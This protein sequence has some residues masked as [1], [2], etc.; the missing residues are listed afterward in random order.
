MINNS[1]N[2]HIIVIAYDPIT[3]WKGQ[4]VHKLLDI[5]QCTF[6]TISSGHCWCLADTHKVFA[7]P[8]LTHAHTDAH[9]HREVDRGYKGVHCPGPRDRRGLELGPH[10]KAYI[11]WGGLLR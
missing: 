4:T 1:C 9:A 8:T 5:L 7:I 2:Y 10:Y 11:E 3:Q 6:C